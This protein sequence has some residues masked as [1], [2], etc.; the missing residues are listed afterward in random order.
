MKILLIEPNIKTSA[1]MPSMSLAILKGFLNEKTKHKAKII[2]LVFHKKIWMNYLIEEIRKEKPDLIGFSIMSFNYAEALEIARFIRDNFS[3]KIIF[4]GVHV[5]LSPQE[6]IENEEID[7]ICTGEGEEVLKELLDNNLNCTNVK[8]IWYKRD[9]EIIKNENRRLIESLDLLAFPDFED[10]DLEKYFASINNNLPI[11]ASRGCPYVCS[12]CSNHALRKKLDGKY[13]RFRS[14]DNVIK[15]IELRIKQLKNKGMK[16]LYFFDDTFILYKDFV[17]EFCEKYK[18]KGFH[19]ILKWSANVRADLVTDEIIK[20]MKDAGCYEARMGVESGNDY[21]RNKVYKRNM[22]EEQIFNAFKIIKDNGLLLR[23]YF[24]F[25]APYETIE[26]MDETLDMAKKSN[27]DMIIFVELLPL[28]GT[29]IKKMFEKENLLECDISRNYLD[30]LVSP[31]GKTKF[32]SKEQVQRFSRKLKK[33]QTQSYIREGINMNGLF[34]FWDILLF[35]LYY[36][37]KYDL[38]AEQVYRWTIQRYNL[39]KIV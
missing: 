30:V 32:A 38:A 7:I 23:L 29:E 35:V 10:F 1:F 5:I 15:E 22:T 17:R 33:W 9:G 13:V 28:P 16:Y 2:D 14:V 25:G 24:M 21:I 19:K 36:K 37:R 3:V 8:G 18:K 26:M 39:N 27:A 31:V 20:T 11:M 4:G 34:F 12:Y 6:V